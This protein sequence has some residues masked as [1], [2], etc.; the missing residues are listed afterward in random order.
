MT[1]TEWSADGSKWL[2]VPVIEDADDDERWHWKVEG[3]AVSHGSIWHGWTG[4]GIVQART[5]AE[6]LVWLAT[7]GPIH[8]YGLDFDAEFTITISPVE[9]EA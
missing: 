8:G 7:D 2:P 6:A 3:T 4:E 9:Q 1:E 5:S